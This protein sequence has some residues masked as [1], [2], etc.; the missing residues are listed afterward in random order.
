MTE[1]GEALDPHE[2]LMCMDCTGDVF[3]S[4]LIE[5][6][7]EPARCSYCGNE[8]DC[9][10]IDQF[11]DLIEGVFGDY[12]EMTSN[13]PDGFQSHMLADR[14]SNYE[15]NRSGEP[16]ANIIADIARVDEPVAHDAQSVLEERHSDYYEENTGYE[17]FGSE[18]HYG[19]KEADSG[20][21]PVLWLELQ[22][23]LVTE[24]RLFNRGA[25]AIMEQVFSG[26]ASH[27]TRDKRGVIREAGPSA[28]LS[29]FYRARVIQD[30]TVLKE[31]MIHPDRE[32]G[33]PPT[34]SSAAGRMNA[35]GISVFYGATAPEVALAE[36][37]PPVGSRVVVVRFKL[38]RRLRLLD[39]EALRSVYIAGSVFDPAFKEQRAL[40]NFLQNLSQHI[41]QPVMPNDEPFEYIATQ[42]IAD[43]LATE[44]DPPIDGL[45]YP[46]VQ[47]GT[48]E[49][50]VV[51]F[52]KAAR[53][54]FLE[55][56]PGEVLT[57]RYYSWGPEG[58]E[59]DYRVRVT[60][61]PPPPVK[62]EYAITPQDFYDDRPETLA[63]DLASMQIHH[64]S[65]V[66]FKTIPHDVTRYVDDGQNPDF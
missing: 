23:S 4:K 18:T 65:A 41:T 29:A 53:V 47:T 35:R 55:T 17:P 63:V 10:T 6:D 60:L 5:R 37:R 21:F 3:L 16:T 7:G 45:L 58:Y 57:A 11:A 13:E 22:R 42:A 33:P 43:Y 51:L 44:A 40:A 14:E 52:Q 25:Q 28:E 54:R 19:M 46:S 56:P 50:N 36:V 39:V 12:F 30:E 20:R 9:I 15:W 1:D 62:R 49:L 59:P 66:K 34:R 8:A 26:I 48:G 38:L 64:V 61:K 2:R 31:A 24:A 32:I 27:T